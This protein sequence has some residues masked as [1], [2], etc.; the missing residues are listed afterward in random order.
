MPE[1]TPNSMLN[2]WDYSK[3]SMVC[4]SDRDCTSYKK[5]AEFLG[6]TIED[7]G[8]GTGW[9]KR[10]FKNYR[11]VDGSLHPNVDEVVDLVKYTSKVENILLRQ[12]L[13]LNEDWKKIIDNAKRSFSK[14]LCIVV[15]SPFSDGETKIGEVEAAKDCNDELRGFDHILIFFKKQDILDCFPINEFKV[16]EETVE[17]EQGYNQDWI[18]YVERL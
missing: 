14:K 9:A 3:T 8:G 7:W 1:I 6:D 2:K 15:F 13:S 18:L 5:A 10:Y 11:N 12:V 16:S 17:T 4:Y